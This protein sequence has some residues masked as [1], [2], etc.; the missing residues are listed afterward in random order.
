MYIQVYTPPQ[1]MT[2]SENNSYV[3]LVSFIA[4]LGGLLFGFDI[5]IISG[6]VPFIK[7]YFQLNEIELGWGVSALL[8]GCIPG[9]MLAGRLADQFGRK[10]ILICIAML[11]AVTSILTALASDFTLFIITRLIGGLTVGATSVISPLYIAEIAPANS[12]GKLVSLNQLTITIGIFVSYFINFLLHDIGES[13]WRW[14]FASGAVPAIVFLGLLFFVPESPRWLFLHG[15]RPEALKIMQRI[16]GDNAVIE[17][18]ES[19]TERSN[20]KGKL[21]EL[22]SP[23][24]RRPA[25]VGIVLAIFVQISGINT[26]I[27]YAPIILKSAGNSLDTALFQT[28][29]I[30]FI[31]FAFTFVAIFTIDK[32]GRKPLYIIG[33]TGMTISL[34]LLGLGFLVGYAEGVVGLILILFFIAFFAAFIGPVF[35]VLMSELFPERIRSVAISIAVFTNWLTNFVVVLFFPY[36]L[37]NAGGAVAFFVLALM[38]LLMLIFTKKFVPETKGRTLEEI[39]Q[40]WMI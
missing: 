8:V 9:A 31:N 16:G 7:D 39:D 20:G 33:A 17:F 11:F 3:F 5:A 32:V 28:F 21:L 13:N 23:P 12:R 22:F 34:A 2:E 29:I 24:Y 25:I 14:M 36:V 37:K 10:S 19:Y 26:I 6:A 40:Q 38:A 18:N 4:A 15:K 27:D 1:I 35:W 30:G